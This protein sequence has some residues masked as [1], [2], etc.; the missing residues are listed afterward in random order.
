MRTVRF[1]VQVLLV[2]L[3][4]GM[5][6]A[7]PLARIGSTDV[8]A[9]VVTG[10]VLAVLNALAGHRALASAQGKSFTTFLRVVLLGAGIRMAVLLGALVL[11]IRLAGMHP[12]ALTVS[13]L[14]F[15]VVFLVLEILAIQRNVLP[16]N[17]G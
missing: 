17:Q 9:A 10:A 3:A 11:L 6:L 2:L 15:Y 16:P 12:V 7:F 5:L 4:G 13:L 8:T 1:P 14:G